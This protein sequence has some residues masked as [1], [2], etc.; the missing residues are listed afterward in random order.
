MPL[1]MFLMALCTSSGDIKPYV[2]KIDQQIMFS[3][4]S[5][6]SYQVITVDEG[7]MTVKV[8]LNPGHGMHYHSHK[9]RDEVWTVVEG[10]GRAIIDGKVIDVNAGD[11]LR[12]KS[13][14]K[15]KIDALTELKLIEVQIGSEISVHDKE[16]WPIS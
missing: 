2:D 1:S 3:E 11:V 4:K 6:G 7:S 16:K 12:M 8:T 15:H 10:T 9:L 5:W 13:G 14:Q